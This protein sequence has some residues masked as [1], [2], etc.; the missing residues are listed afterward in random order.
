MLSVHVLG[1]WAYHRLHQHAGTPRWIREHKTMRK[2]MHYLSSVISALRNRSGVSSV[3]FAVA[4][5][6]FVTLLTVLV[7]FGIGQG[8]AQLFAQLG[9][10]LSNA[11]PLT[12]TASG[13]RV[14]DSS[15]NVWWFPNLLP[16]TSGVI[17]LYNSNVP[18]VAMLNTAGA[19]GVVPIAQLPDNGTFAPFIAQQ[20]GGQC[21][22]LWGWGGPPAALTATGQLV[23][24]NSLLTYPCTS[25]QQSFLPV[26]A[27]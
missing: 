19:G 15:N 9:L 3:E 23:F 7:D 16:A 10:S 4:L 6:L 27:H 12:G 24:M 21:Y 18:F 22:L 8:G 1:A 2:A 20:V 5:P 17:T 25:R 14:V 26:V 11:L 13:G